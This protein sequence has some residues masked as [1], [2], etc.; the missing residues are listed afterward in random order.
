MTK[1]EK[2]LESIKEIFKTLSKEEMAK[3]IHK[4]DLM[5]KIGPTIDEYLANINK[6]SQVNGND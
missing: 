5:P 4:I 1:L 2:S 6:N 3:I